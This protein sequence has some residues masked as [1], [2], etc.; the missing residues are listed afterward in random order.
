MSDIEG[1][2]YRTQR[3]LRKTRAEVRAEIEP[4]LRRREAFRRV[5]NGE[6]FIH[7]KRGSIL[8]ELYGNMRFNEEGIINGE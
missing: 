7:E 8:L 1:F 5:E 3:P 2:D 4:M 6:T